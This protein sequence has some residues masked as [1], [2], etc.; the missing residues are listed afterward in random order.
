MRRAHVGSA[1]GEHGAEGAADLMYNGPICSVACPPLRPSIPSPPLSWSNVGRC[2]EWHPL[3]LGFPRVRGRPRL[4]CVR[5]CVVLSLRF[6]LVQT[7]EKV[8]CDYTLFARVEKGAKQEKGGGVGGSSC[9]NSSPPVS[10]ALRHPPPPPPSAPTPTMHRC[11]SATM[12]SLFCFCELA[13]RCTPGHAAPFFLLLCLSFTKLASLPP[14]DLP[15]YTQTHTHTRKTR[16]L[17]LSA[18]ADAL[19]NN[20]WPVAT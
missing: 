17:I 11:S 10:P 15:M 14:T 6:K 12:P 1:Q 19:K 3:V 16:A 2:T 13:S 7:W 18:P 20:Q 4:F 8:S 5:V 9:P